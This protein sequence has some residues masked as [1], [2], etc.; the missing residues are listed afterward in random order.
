MESEQEVELAVR[1]VVSEEMKR[2]PGGGSVASG[3]GAFGLALLFAAFV[4]AFGYL[5]WKTL[6]DSEARL[7][8]SIDSRLLEFRIATELRERVDAYVADALDTAVTNDATVET[9]RALI[10]A[11]TTRALDEVG[12]AIDS[13]VGNLVRVSL[14]NLPNGTDLLGSIQVPSGAVLAFDRQ[15]CPDGWSNYEEGVGR[16]IIG[17]G[18]GNNLTPRRVGDTGGEEQVTLT[19]AQMPAHRHANPTTG[20]NQVI[21]EV[22]ALP[23]GGRGSYGPQHARPTDAAGQSQPHENMPPYIALLL[24]RKS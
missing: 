13:R 15:R 7:A 21:E 16:A 10:D 12:P 23:I 11:Q 4:L 1:R 14:S 17:A 3:V 20:N 24:C 5:H 22:N 18:R 19:L 9:I 2:R 6:S 8:A